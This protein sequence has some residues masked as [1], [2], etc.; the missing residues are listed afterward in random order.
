MYEEPPE[1]DTLYE[2]PPVVGALRWGQGCQGQPLCGHRMC[3]V[4]FQVG[5]ACAISHLA[6]ATVLGGELVAHPL[7]SGLA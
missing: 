3:V 2:E 4:L 5:A 7:P 1:Q 6:S